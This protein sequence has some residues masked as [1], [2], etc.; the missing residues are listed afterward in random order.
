MKR[1]AIFL[2][3]S[4]VLLILTGCLPKT[5]TVSGFVKD[6]SG[7]PIPDVTVVIG[8][9]S[10]TTD[11]DGY[12][13]VV[14]V[15]TGA[16]TVKAMKAGYQDYSNTVTVVAKTVNQHNIT[17]K[18]VSDSGN[19]LGVV[20][21]SLTN[22]PISGVAVKLGTYTTTTDS[23]GRYRFLNIAPNTYT[24]EASRT[25]Y[26]SKATSVSIEVNVAK[27]LNIQL[28]STVYGNVAGIVRDHS[29][30][31]LKGVTISA[32]GKTATSG[33]DG[34]Y[35]VYA[36]PAGVKTI[37]AEK[38]GFLTASGQVTVV[39]G[40]EVAYDFQLIAA[41]TVRG[42]VTDGRGGPGVA[43]AKITYLTA[44]TTTTAAGTFQLN[45]PRDT[46]GDLF[47]EKA[48]RGTV[49]VQDLQFAEGQVIDLEIPSQSL[50]N[51]SWSKNPPLIEANIHPGQS[52]TG[53]VPLHIQVSGD[54]PIVKIFV[55]FGGEQRL[56]AQAIVDGT[57]DTVDTDLNTANYPNGPQVL[58]VLAYDDNGNAALLRVP[59]EVSN[60]SDASAHPKD[61]TK[62]NITSYTFGANIG[63]YQLQQAELAK[64]KGMTTNPNLLQLPNRTIDLTAAPPDANLFVYLNWDL[65]Q[66][67]AGYSVYRSFDGVYYSLIGNVKGLQYEDF[68][69]QL[70]VNQATYYRVV[71]YN[72]VGVGQGKE[73]YVIPTPPFNVL[74]LTPMNQ[75]TNVSL[76]PTFTWKLQPHTGFL[77]PTEFFSKIHLYDDQGE[78]IWETVVNSQTEMSY[79]SSLQPGRLYSWDIT[80]CY[81]DTLY[82]DDDE[83]DD[84]LSRAISIAGPY[85]SGAPYGV[86]SLNGKF[87]FTTTT[88]TQ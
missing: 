77:Y 65:V 72:S 16:Q 23:Q 33:N 4:V 63:F 55:Y 71:P 58:R 75:E 26:T 32:G 57:S 9:F 60:V 44:T 10:T 39:A 6:L 53:T 74:L 83:I 30:N 8:T 70:R 45:V 54:R 50:F 52:L 84:G 85:V 47:V 64:K 87:I 2:L 40:T 18:P 68:S 34:K 62:L 86:G 24:F 37:T 59:V 11:Y 46:V 78:D 21:D 41:S 56:P 3:L 15:P 48:N 61:M 12:Y 14:K 35:R 51:P 25:G 36:V 76:T 13:S 29:G 31:P 80:E 66:G 88:S 28:V 67:A 7:T 22:S 38:A 20:V 27:S 1:K 73:F 82:V 43:D 42:Y 69:A 79:N 5:G 49:R 17:I 81:T 19:L